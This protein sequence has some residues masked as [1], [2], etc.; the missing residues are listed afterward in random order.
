MMAYHRIRGVRLIVYLVDI[1]VMAQDPEKLKL[2]IRW[3]AD[4]LQ[5]L[6]FLLNREKSILLPSTSLEFLGF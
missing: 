5:G 2:H 1:L 4:L 6:E 3:T